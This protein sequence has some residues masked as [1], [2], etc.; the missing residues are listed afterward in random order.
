MTFTDPIADYLTRIR[1][2]I[3][4]G[5]G[6]VRIPASKLKVELSRILKDEGYIDGYEVEPATVGEQIRVVLRYV[7]DR[8]VIAGLQRVSR[9][10]RRAYV[11]VDQI[12]R[13]LGGMGVAVLSTSKGVL[14]G[15][16]A[17]GARVG[18]EHLLNVW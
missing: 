9:P 12:P 3:V 11:S 8:S 13:V 6:E 14:T 2:G 1:N 5:H 4:A 16:R 18:G 17:R 15:Q 10:G 7:D